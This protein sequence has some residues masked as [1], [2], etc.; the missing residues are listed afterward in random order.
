MVT[1]AYDVAPADYEAFN[2]HWA[3]HPR[4]RARWRRQM[5]A[6]VLLVPWMPVLVLNVIDNGFRDIEL[7]PDVLVPAGAALLVLAILIPISY[8]IY[9]WRV[10][11]AVRTMLGRAPNEDFLGSKRL[12]A[13]EQ[14]LRLSGRASSASYDWS[15]VQGIEETASHLFV[16]L[17]SA[18]AIIVPK[19]GQADAVVDALRAAI[20]KHA[21]APHT[22]P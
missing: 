2:L 3:M 6:M 5:I 13:T 15:A 11:R 9:P 18:I 19:R 8:A 17:G 12:E 7:V 1:L 4:L 10:R 16:M 14:G 21:G 22:V 20:R